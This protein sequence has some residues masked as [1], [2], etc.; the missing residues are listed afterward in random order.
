MDDR[1]MSDTNLE[2]RTD[3]KVAGGGDD[4]HDDEFGL[5][6]VSR[7]G[8]LISKLVCVARFDSFLAF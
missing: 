1:W 7:A 3:I 5:I 2:M 8:M 6:P 4:T